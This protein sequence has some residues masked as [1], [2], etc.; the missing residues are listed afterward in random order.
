M[1]EIKIKDQISPAKAEIEDVRST[2]ESNQLC[3]TKFCTIW[4][5]LTFPGGWEKSRLKTN[6]AQLKLKL[7]LS[8]AKIQNMKIKI[9]PYSTYKDVWMIFSFPLPD[10]YPTSIFSLKIPEFSVLGNF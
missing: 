7:G 2:Y 8:L 10:F 6:S 4:N 9:N 1:G 3:F 5:F